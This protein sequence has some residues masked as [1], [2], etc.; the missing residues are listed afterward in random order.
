MPSI[1]QRAWARTLSVVC[2][3]WVGLAFLRTKQMAEMIGVSESEVRAIGVRDLGN[4]LALAISSDP[5]G[6]LGL[7]ALFDLSDAARYGRR[8]PK[9]LAMTVGFAALGALGLLAGK[10]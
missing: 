1:S 5:R 10:R 8:R 9:V 6:A 3:W 7:R 4:G 2:A